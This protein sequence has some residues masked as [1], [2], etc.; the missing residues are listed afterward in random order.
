MLTKTKHSYQNK[1]FR[2]QADRQK[3]NFNV[4]A[5]EVSKTASYV[6]KRYL[7]HLY[8]ITYNYLKEIV[9]YHL[10]IIKTVKFLISFRNSAIYRP[11]FLKYVA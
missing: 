3:M 11:Y 6:D 9:Q 5:P 7:C 8:T 10:H 4:S 1:N 2:A